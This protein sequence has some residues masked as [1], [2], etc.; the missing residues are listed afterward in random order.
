[1]NSQDS[2]G[3]VYMDMIQIALLNWCLVSEQETWAFYIK[4]KNNHVYVSGKG[5][6]TSIIIDP[7]K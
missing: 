5:P 6:C 2:V 7:V 4:N 3:C 1:M